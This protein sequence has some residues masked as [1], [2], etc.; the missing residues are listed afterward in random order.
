MKTFAEELR[1]LYDAAQSIEFEG[2]DE[3]AKQAIEKHIIVP[4]EAKEYWPVWKKE[5]TERQRK[6]LWGKE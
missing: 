6:S 4:Q 2:W 1:D 5:L 3:T